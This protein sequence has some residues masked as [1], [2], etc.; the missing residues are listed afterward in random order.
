MFL[1]TLEQIFVSLA[2]FLKQPIVSFLHNIILY[3]LSYW[4]DGQL[5]SL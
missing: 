4:S 5:N 2:L 3:Q 1:D